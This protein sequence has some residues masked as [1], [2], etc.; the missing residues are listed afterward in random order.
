MGF[1]ACWVN[2]AGAVLQSSRAMPRNRAVT[3]VSVN[4]GAGRF[5]DFD[6]FGIVAKFE[7]D[8]LDNPVGLIFQLDDAFLTKKLVKRNLAF[9]ESRCYNLLPFT[10][11][12]TATATAG[13]RISGLCSV[14][15]AHPRVTLP[16]SITVSETAMRT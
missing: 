10:G 5:P 15:H 3:R 11:A 13:S 14:V 6:C 4:V 12:T 7:T 9:D 2:S 8:F 16:G 1:R